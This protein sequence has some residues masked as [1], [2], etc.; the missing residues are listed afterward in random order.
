MRVACFD[1]VSIGSPQSP[2]SR[3]GSARGVVRKSRKRKKALQPERPSSAVQGRTTCFNEQ[4]RVVSS[5][6]RLPRYCGL[7]RAPCIIARGLV[8][9]HKAPRRVAERSISWTTPITDSA[10]GICNNPATTPPSVTPL[11]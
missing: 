8:K 10:K 2:P 9:S 5:P 6:A 3:S 4:L 11:A 7:M 1:L